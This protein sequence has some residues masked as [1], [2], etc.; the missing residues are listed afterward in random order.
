M[1]DSTKTTA[2]IN[3]EYQHKLALR[4]Q[5][6][7]MTVADLISDDEVP[8][9]V[10]HWLERFVAEGK[11]ALE[12]SFVAQET[13]TMEQARL[14]YDVLESGGTETRN[15]EF[16]AEARDFVEEYLYRLAEATAQQV[17]NNGEIAIAAL[18]TMLDC[19][20]ASDGG[21][22][23][24]LMLEI[25]VR[26]LTTAEE[27]RNFLTGHRFTGETVKARNI[28]AGYK[29]ARLLANPQT[30]SDTRDK[31]DSALLEFA[32]QANINVTHAALAQRVFT[33][34][35]DEMS[36]RRRGQYAKSETAHRRQVYNDLLAL[37]DSLQG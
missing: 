28:E 32:Q 5:P 37:L 31:L 35:A 24:L 3:R 11:R 9:N 33:L 4:E 10:R 23:D 25:A 12:R 17:W 21:A 2:E 34:A 36:Q 19:A 6:A 15:R 18:P 20:N 30:D 22:P 1:K 13:A 26:R 8:V 27:R 16:S 29:L 7:A 14:I